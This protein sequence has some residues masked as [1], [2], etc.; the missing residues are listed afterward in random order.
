M[1]AV[2]GC[3]E[4]YNKYCQKGEAEDEGGTGSTRMVF[5]FL[6]F[7]CAGCCCCQSQ[8]SSA[9]WKC[10][11]SNLGYVPNQFCSKLRPQS[12]CASGID[13]SDY[14][15]F[16]WL[17]YTFD[18]WSSNCQLDIWSHVNQTPVSTGTD[19][20]AKCAQII[21]IFILIEW[22]SLLVSRWDFLTCKDRHN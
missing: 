4:S 7:L 14:E 20:G 21:L 2:I 5:C 15:I 16:P 12:W 8:W 3:E 13:C 18:F 1:L 22:K 6:F 11:Y 10:L 17:M 19:T 9:W